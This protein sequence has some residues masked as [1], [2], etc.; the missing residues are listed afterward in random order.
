MLFMHALHVK[1]HKLYGGETSTDVWYLHPHKV[2]YRE[3][4]HITG[5]CNN[6]NFEFFPYDSHAC[7]FGM[8]LLNVPTSLFVLDQPTLYKLHINEDVLQEQE[9]SEVC[10]NAPR[11]NFETCISTDESLKAFQMNSEDGTT[12]SVM[13]LKVVLT[14]NQGS[15]DKII[16]GYYVP[17]GIFA[18]M[19]MISFAIQPDIVRGFD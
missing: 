13:Q 11:L 12:F 17:T 8:V 10:I 14:R 15:L 9:S 3:T 19:S 7:Y 16:I 18:L 5:L 1:G 2:V 6:M 4:M